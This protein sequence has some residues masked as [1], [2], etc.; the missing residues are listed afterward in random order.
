MPDR[1]NRTAL[2]LGGSKG[3]GFAVARALA[4]DKVSCGLVGRNVETLD[5]A[6]R[7]LAALGVKAE[8]F[9]H[10]LSASDGIDRLITDVRARLG[11]IDILV[12]NGGGPPPF[13]ASSFDAGAWNA[14]FR[15]LVFNQID[16]A[17]RLLPDMRANGWG[18]ILVV[19][20]T[21][22]REPIPGLTASNAMRPALAG[23]A[24]TLAGEVARD[25]VTVNVLMP[26]RIATDRTTQL[27][28]LDAKE[29]GVDAAVVS[30]ESQAEIPIG[31][32]GT[33]DEFAAIAAFLAGAGGAYVT[34]TAIPVDGGL[35]LGMI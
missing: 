6:A 11:K 29:R 30:A 17:T 31:R 14:A 35:S 1:E 8:T 5:R 9:P 7:E 34:G 10:D 15:S 25:G 13:P 21:S 26:G 33:P 4:A 27:D 19:S 2:V 12:L 3:L 32:Y 22:I 28:A 23:W 20:S 16:I 18:R 24:K